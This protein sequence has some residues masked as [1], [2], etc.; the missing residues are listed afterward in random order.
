MRGVTGEI[1]TALA[2][3][4]FGG[5]FPKLAQLAKRPAIVRSYSSRN[6]EHTYQSVTT[7]GNPL[8]AAVSSLYTRVA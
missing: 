5:T 3:I 4:T 2:S 7:A 6:V 8:K 1:K